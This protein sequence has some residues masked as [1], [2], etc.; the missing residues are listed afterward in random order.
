M[1]RLKLSTPFLRLT[2]MLNSKRR[3]SQLF[4]PILRDSR[5]HVDRLALSDAHLGV[6]LVLDGANSLRASLQPTDFADKLL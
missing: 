3:P 4:P 5:E 2:D 6:V 1:E